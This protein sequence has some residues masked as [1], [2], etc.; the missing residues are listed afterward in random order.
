M[1]QA[2]PPD[3]A[4]PL[5][6]DP[7]APNDVLRAKRVLIVEDNPF[8]ALALEELLVERGLIVATVAR[9]VPAALAAASALEFDVALLDVNI[10]GEKTTA[11]AD[12]LTRRAAPFIFATGYG[13]AGL[14]E[15][16]VDHAVVE[17]PFYGEEILNALRDA[18]VSYITHEK[19]V[20]TE[21]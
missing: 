1:S 15:G 13:R 4:Q 12:I 2:Q 10:G 16:Y 18:I 6:A 9:T 20:K 3:D 8:V 11:V 5:G 14:P 7:N 17:K 21:P 19:D